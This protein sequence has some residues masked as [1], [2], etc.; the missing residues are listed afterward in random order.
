MNE[1]RLVVALVNAVWQTAVIAAFTAGI[2]YLARRSSASARSAVWVLAFFVSAVL[3]LV[4]Y[5]YGNTE[6]IQTS[7]PPVATH[8]VRPAPARAAAT[9]Y[10]VITPARSSAVTRRYAGTSP[11]GAT[12]ETAPMRDL[13]LASSPHP[14]RPAL[15][16]RLARAIDRVSGVLFW[17]WIFGALTLLARVLFQLLLLTRAKLMVTTSGLPQALSGQEDSGRRYAVGLSDSVAVPCLLGLVKPVIAI[18]RSL[19]RELSQGDLKRIILHESAHVRRRDD[20]LN[21]FEQ[22]AL[23]ILFFSP[24]LHFI[25]RRASLEREIACDDQVIASEDR[26]FYAECLSAL[27]RRARLKHAFVVPGFLAGR[28][29][30]LVRIEQL[31][32]RKHVS[33][34]SPGS[35]PYVIVACIA[36]LV[37]VL[38]QI[39]IP[40]LAAAPLVPQATTRDFVIRPAAKTTPAIT[41]TV[42]VV[43]QAKRVTPRGAHVRVNRQAG[44]HVITVSSP[45]R[46]LRRSIIIS[47]NKVEKTKRIE[48]FAAAPAPMAMGVSASGAAASG[49]ALAMAGN[50]MVVLSGGPWLDAQAP[51]RSVD[52]SVTAP[53][54]AATVV[55]PPAP[56]S[57]PKPSSKGNVIFVIYSLHDAQ[58]LIDHGVTDQ[59]IKELQA[60][61]YTVLKVQD[62]TALADHGVSAAYAAEVRAAGLRASVQ[63]LTALRDHDVS[64]DYIKSMRALI[65][66]EADLKAMTTLR[67]HDVSASLAQAASELA[68]SRLDVKALTQ[69][70]D[71]GVT[72]D[73]LRG[74]ARYRYSFPNNQL[75]DIAVKEITELR[76]HGVTTEYIASLAAAGYSGLSAH[77]IIRLYDHGVSAEFIQRVR[78]THHNTLFSVDELVRMYDSGG[79]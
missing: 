29:Q 17:V 16:T 43:V 47:L 45:L 1:P 21:L 30:L 57:K 73:Y 13:A 56:P 44:G 48:V 74:M 76:D 34:A 78:R 4:N 2:L 69:L 14:A 68:R 37:I 60:A 20:W 71:H 26:V 46:E 41:K 75:P 36:A 19:A 40:A 61:G 11:T 25:A 59:Y 27:A 39:G 49:S 77:D 42:T 7:Q 53:G 32:D 10:F 5:A 3:P 6:T 52:L 35:L 23:A 15:R 65:H 58:T 24:A 18:P 22:L 72:A 33:A 51:P 54:P 79:Y 12:P 9:A 62:L 50:R 38:C 66:S 8:P 28:R 67:D 70:S 55:L 31:L 63:A 64:A